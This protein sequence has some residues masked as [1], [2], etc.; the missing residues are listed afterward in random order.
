MLW[1][2]GVN[3]HPM[4]HGKLMAVVTRSRRTTRGHFM[5]IKNDSRTLYALNVT[6]WVFEQ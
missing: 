6:L 5:L 2:Y 1:L 3:D 4:T